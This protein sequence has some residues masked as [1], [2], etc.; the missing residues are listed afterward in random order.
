MDLQGNIRVACRLKPAVDG[1]AADAVVLFE[2]REGTDLVLDTPAQRHHF[3]FDRVHAAE[4]AQSDVSEDVQP[5]TDAV[6]DGY[7][8]CVLAYG[9]VRSRTCHVP[10]CPTALHSMRTHTLDADAAWN[11]CRGVPQTG[12]GKTY[13][14][15]G[16]IHNP[17]VIPSAVRG[18][19]EAA[20]TSPSIDSLSVRV[21][22]LRAPSSRGR[23]GGRRC[24]S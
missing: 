8:V 15:Q 2:L 17:G 13:T 23:G 14:M 10:G 4:A 3:E 5:L 9:Q 21:R 22:V 1:P 18:L 7:N 19:F 16:S 12:S 6:L 11:A 20:D 24:I